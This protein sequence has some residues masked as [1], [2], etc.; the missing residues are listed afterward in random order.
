MLPPRLLALSALAVLSG[1]SLRPASAQD[2]YYITVF[3]SGSHPLA[4]RRTHTFATVSHVQQTPEGPVAVNDTISWMP[5]TLHIRPFAL[6]PEPGVNLT[7]EE[8]LRWAE[9]VGIRTSMW[10]PF[11]IT[12]ERYAALMARKADLENGRIAYRAVGGFTKSAPV[13]NCG[14]SFAR[15]GVVGQKFLEPTPYPGEQGTS[16]LVERGIRTAPHPVVERPELRP[17]IVS[18]DH[19]V[20]VRDPAERIPR[21]RR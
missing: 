12:P 3:G 20:T 18:P 21:F 13:S 5:A 8:S 14:Q 9:S 17:A 7:Q 10:G 11:E 16:K 4:T 1:F 6:R 15:A 2:G 19:P